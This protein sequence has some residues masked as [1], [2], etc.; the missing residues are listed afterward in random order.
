MMDVIDAVNDLRRVTHTDLAA[1]V[2][3]VAV[4]LT[5]PRSGSS[6][7]KSVL[8][9]HPEIASLDGEMEPFLALTRNGFSFNAG[10]DALK[11]I[12][13]QG[14]LLDNIFDDM[15][16][17]AGGESDYLF[18]KDRWRKRLLLQFPALF[19]ED[20][21]H[22]QLIHD[23]DAVFRLAGEKK[24]QSEAM[25]QDLVLSRVFKSE[26]WRLDYYDGKKNP[27]ASHS[28]NEP[29]KLEEPPFVVPRQHRRQLEP[30]DVE[31]KI[32]LFKT[33]PDVYRIGM[34]EQLFPNARIRYL[35][36]TRGYAQ[37]V[38]GLMDG[39]L[40]PVAFFSHDLERIGLNLSI[41]GYSDTVSFGKRWWK[42][43]LPPNWQEYLNT[44]LEEV[45]LNQWL[46][47]HQAIID[48]RV[49]SL[50]VSFEEFLSDP[51]GIIQKITSYLGLPEM[52]S[53]PVFPVTMATEAPKIRRWHKRETDLLRMG[54]RKD[55]Q[56]MMDSL[57]YSM[58][59]ETWL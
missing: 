24:I 17:P 10:S 22:E 33:P 11:S 59:P 15:T 40:S 31:Q 29:F 35:H 23:L 51:A 56:M 57:A 46:S 7:L 34:Y 54:K 30:D 13:N 4:I 25:L 52:R 12:D 2:K 6:L 45:C 9:S 49:T 37:S 44:N 14:V 27:A 50:S 38:N 5:S 8:S 20:R 41:R 26:I 21:A 32:L 28:F 3:N 55:V 39:W 48:S 58:N 1:R 36:L 47:A 42:F 53:L 18:L 43:D 19:S 16:L